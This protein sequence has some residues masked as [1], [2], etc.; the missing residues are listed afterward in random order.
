MRTVSAP[1]RLPPLP[2]SPQNQKELGSLDLLEY[3]FDGDDMPPELELRFLEPGGDADQLREMEDR[4]LVPLPRGGL[5]L[6]LPRVQ[7][8]MAEGA[9]GDLCVASRL[10]RLLDR[11][12]ELAERHLLPCLDD[13][14]AAALDLRRVVDSLASAGLD[15]RLERP[16]PVGILETEE[17]R[18]AEDLAAVEGRDTKAL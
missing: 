15:D 14:K 3:A 4:H 16:R 5:E 8:E 6:L 11:L 2:A 7:R 18:R 10:D 17:L 1:L 12:E 13:R 9:R